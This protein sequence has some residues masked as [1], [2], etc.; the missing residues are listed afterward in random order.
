[1]RRR[2]DVLQGRLQQCPAAVRCLIL[3]RPNM[4]TASP[5]PATGWSAERGAPRLVAPPSPWAQQ[6]LGS[7]PSV[8]SGGPPV[9][10]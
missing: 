8:M 6:S 3:R 7:P 5:L 1:M 9:S 4:P 2:V 10:A